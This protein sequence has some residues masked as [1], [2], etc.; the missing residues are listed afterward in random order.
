MEFIVNNWG[1]FLII[2]TAIAG[3]VFFI[4]NDKAKAKKWLLYAVLEAEK[5]FG[6]KTGVV[7]LRYVYTWFIE[8]YPVFSKFISFDTFSKMVDEVLVEMRHLID[9]N[10]AI[11]DYVKSGVIL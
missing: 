11:S 5:Q 6:S 8:K 2:F 4:K 10:I 3:G 1:I 9:T 7:K